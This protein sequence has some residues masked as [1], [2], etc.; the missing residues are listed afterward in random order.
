MS[1]T[2]TAPPYQIID[3]L[4]PG[5][6]FYHRCLRALRKTCGIY[7]LLPSSHIIPQGLTLV[8]TN[9]MKRPVASGGFS[10]VW[11]AGG[12]GGQIFAI[13][14]FRIYDPDDSQYVRKDFCKQV[15][16]SRRIRHENVLSIEGVAPELF[17]LC[18]VSKWLGNGN[19]LQFVRAHVG[20]DRRG[21]LVGITRGL[22]HLHSNE[23]VHGDL[24]GPNILIDE[25]GNP[26]LSDFGLSS[27]TR[28]VTSVNASTPRSGGTVRWSAPEL[29][30]ALFDKSK[31]QTP[32]T[33]S[34]V[35][36]LSM[37]IIELYTGHIPFADRRDPSVILMVA[38]GKRP[39]KPASAEALGL[40]PGVW[41]LTK[42]CWHKKS[43]RRP[44]TSEILAHLESMLSP[45]Y[46]NVGLLMTW[47][48][49][50][51]EGKSGRFFASL[52]AAVEGT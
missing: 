6:E 30:E 24:K 37:V 48:S 36:A 5:S 15:I 17:D 42:K 40:T 28:N 10:D 22:H 14:H 50:D 25:R 52:R 39:P 20:V 33:K 46:L 38:K 8:T 41:E 11:R 12:N 32:T 7:G 45:M 3:T 29:L 31:K 43:S 35:Y 18:L 34:D 16:I 27:V 26:L 1:S 4:S 23:V 49:I 2:L 13:K 51:R 19:M 21:L 44:D 47:K 9:N